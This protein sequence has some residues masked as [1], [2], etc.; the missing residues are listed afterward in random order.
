MF[1]AG[2]ITEWT[3]LG[4]KIMVDD[5]EYE[6]MPK[7]D[8]WMAHATMPVTA[9]FRLRRRKFKNSV[10]MALYDPRGPAGTAQWY[11]AA[12]TQQEEED[13]LASDDDFVPDGDEHGDV[14]GSGS[15]S[16]GED[17]MNNV[18]VQISNEEVDGLMEDAYG[19]EAYQRRM[20]LQP[21]ENAS[22]YTPVNPPLPEPEDQRRA[23]MK[24]LDRKTKVS[25]LRLGN[26]MCQYCTGGGR[27]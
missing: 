19:E 13:M 1:Y 8:R 17:Y 24:S 18:D 2:T 14:D 6:N 22:Q 10:W 11:I 12:T 25:P 3:T 26:D 16:D 5:E 20:D 27:V 23:R 9:F 21:Q 15:G 4:Q 7:Q